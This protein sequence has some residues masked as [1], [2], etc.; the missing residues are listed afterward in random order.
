MVR[1][2]YI[3]NKPLEEAFALL[4]TELENAGFFVL[5]GEEVDVEDALGRITVVPVVAKRS[6]PHYS[7]SAMDGIAVKAKDTFSASDTSPIVLKRGEQFIEVDTGDYVPGEFDAVIMIEDVNFLSHDEAEIIAPAVPWQHIRSV[8]EDVIASQMIIPSLYVI[9]AYEIGAMLTSGVT[10]VQVVKKPRVGIIP[11]GTELVEPG[12]KEPEPGEIIESN[13]RMLASL[14]RKWGAEPCRYPLVADDKEKIK[15]AVLRC[16]SQT[17][18]IV[19]C[20]GSSAGREDFTAEI[21]QEAGRLLVHGLATKPGKPAILGLI[22]GKPVIG[23]PGYPVSAALVFELLARPL[24]YRKQGLRTPPNQEVEAKISRKLASSMG[25]DEFVQV[26][27]GKVGGELIAYPLGRGAGLTTTL[28]KADGVVRVPRGVEGFEAGEK[29]AVSL[30]RDWDIIEKTLIVIGSH[31][32]AVDWL[33]D[34]LN[35]KFGLRLACTNV[36]SMGGLVALKHRESHFAGMHL[37][38]PKTGEYNVSYVNRYLGGSKP[39]LVNLVL[40]EQG[41]LVKKGNPLGVRGVDDLAGSG[42]RFVNRQRGSGTRVL[43]DHLLQQVGI[44]PGLINGYDREEFSHLAVAAAVKNDAAD[45]AVGIYAA[46][47]AL[48]LDF[49]PL[50]QERYDLCFLKGA[51]EEETLDALL[52]TISSPEF[53]EEVMRFGGYD[54]S[55]A[56][57]VIWEGD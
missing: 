9:G 50:L 48:D 17:D 53:R 33:G 27:L 45:V 15:E 1:R 55:L 25:V 56:G 22:E 54:M 39:V 57:Q 29:V 47:R 10:K 44:H 12:G 5:E 35:R 49:I 36:G 21:V 3:D 38:D 30:K 26:N 40:R 51:I 20:S 32:I 18:I 19:V 23:V 7:A 14:C 52:H 41:L 8:G 13:S 4:W 16:A 24:I 11:T 37:L 31:D 6:S 2:V 34:I 28:V 46:A 43:F 42:V